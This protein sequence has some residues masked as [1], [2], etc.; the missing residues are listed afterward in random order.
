M[1]PGPRSACSVLLVVAAA[2]CTAAS[3]EV[4]PPASGLFFPT[5][6]VVNPTEEF[7]FVNN[8]NSELRYDSGSISVI[9][10]GE[11]DTIAD[12]WVASAAIPAG[13]RQDVDHRETLICNED[14][15]NDEDLPAPG[16]I[17]PDRGVR[18]GN[19]ASAMALQDRGSGQLRLWIGVRGDPSITYADWDGARLTCGDDE[20]FGLC[21]DAHRLTEI[22]GN[23]DFGTIADEPFQI[24]VDSFS[25]FAMVTHLTT[26]TVT[27]VD[28]PAQGTPFLSDV[29]TGLFNPDANNA[30]GAAAVAGR[31]PN[32]PDDL[33]YVTSRT[34]DRVQ[35][36]TV[37]RDA[38]GA[39]ILPSN[40]F[41]LDIAGGNTGGSADTRYATFVD[42]GD[43]LFMVNRAP[44][45]LQI[46]DTSLD[47]SGFPKNTPIAAGDLCREASNMAVADVGDGL[48]AF[49]TCFRDGE[50][51]V[52]DPDPSPQVESIISVGRGPFGIAVSTIHQKL[53]VTNFLDDT[54]A[55]VE[56]APDSPRRYQV[57]LRIGEPR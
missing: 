38:L 9:N 27:L 44:P 6:A 22:D 43:R 37:A 20:T 25:Q 14:P 5:G 50:V 45:S 10:L 15:D 1:A 2:G 48:R 21:D 42:N 17:I 49:I 8:A 41:F 12:G 19:F 7:L 52:M 47:A 34:E 56:L 32:A 57:V 53:Y 51:Y 26:G 30:F 35:M 16:F 3:E 24:F 28:S 29:L 23:P 55:V 31:T 46:Y 13:C 39:F 54:I 40:H 18:V 4:R 11:V 36:L 33:I